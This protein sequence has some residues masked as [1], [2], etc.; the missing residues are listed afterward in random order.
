MAQAKAPRR[1][2]ARGSLGH[3]SWGAKD[4]SAP[5]NQTTSS[6]SLF[7][8]SRK[9]QAEAALERDWRMRSSGERILAEREPRRP[10]QT[11]ANNP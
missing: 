9:R 1:D 11:V 6:A 3:A 10:R 5:R 4:L 2:A 8:R 7:G